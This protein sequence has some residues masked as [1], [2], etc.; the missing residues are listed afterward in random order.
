MKIYNNIIKY[1]DLDTIEK[2]CVDSEIVREML[3]E[4]KIMS[5]SAVPCFLLIFVNNYIE[6]YEGEDGNKWIKQVI[7]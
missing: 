5:I 3:K 7:H 2:I 4:D 6:K 1:S